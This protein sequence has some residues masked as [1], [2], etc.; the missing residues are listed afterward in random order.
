MSYRSLSVFCVLALAVFII[1]PDVFASSSTGMPWE[2]P[3]KTIQQSFT[4]PV[5]F[6]IS[7]IGLVV[8]ALSLI[9]GGGEIGGVAKGIIGV[10]MVI[11]IAVMA[12]NIISLL[13][14]ISGA[15][16]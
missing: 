4:G 16:I 1:S 9:F 14:G 11:S 10:V 13:F 8:C 3:L 12:N 2:N 7:V 15:V 5:A 6:S